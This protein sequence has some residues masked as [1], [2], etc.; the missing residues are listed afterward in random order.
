N[1][2]ENMT[3]QYS[4]IGPGL[5]Q[6]SHSEFPTSYGS[7]DTVIG[8]G[9]DT[10]IYGRRHTYYR[11]FWVHNWGRNFKFEHVD[12]LDV[13]NCVVYDWGKEVAHANPRGFNAVGNMFKKGP[14]T[15]ASDEVWEPDPYGYYDDSIYAP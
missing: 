6:S 11:N 7:N 13:I 10:R 3:I 9:E 15:H 5:Y 2:I 14:E 8:S 1:L 12:G 4:I